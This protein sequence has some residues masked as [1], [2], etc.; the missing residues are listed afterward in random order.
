MTQAA[1]RILQSE[2]GGTV[3]GGLDELTVEE[4]SGFASILRVAKRR[5]SEQLEVAVD[6][7]LEIVPRLLRRPVRKILFG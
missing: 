1:R 5:Q 2:L 7:A 6:E 3:P 4:L